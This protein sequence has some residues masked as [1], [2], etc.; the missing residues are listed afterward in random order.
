MAV[1]DRNSKVLLLELADL[2]DVNS[3]YEAIK[4]QNDGVL[5][6]SVISWAKRVKMVWQ[7]CVAVMHMHGRGILHRDL[8]P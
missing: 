8:K 6:L 3:Y 2:G 7:L 1:T 4:K 5:P